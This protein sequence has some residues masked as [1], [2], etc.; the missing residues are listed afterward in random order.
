MNIKNLSVLFLSLVVL[1]ACVAGSDSSETV[2]ASNQTTTNYVPPVTQ[3]VTPPVTPPTSPPSTASWLRIPMH[4]KILLGQPQ[5]WNEQQ[6]TLALNL[7]EYAAKGSSTLKLS[8]SASLVR[9]QLLSYRGRDGQY[10]SAQI[11]SISN[12]N[13]QLSTPLQQDVFAGGNAWDFYDDGSHPTWVGSR[14]IADF[15][16]RYLGYNR[17]NQG[18]HVLLG[19]SW[20]SRQSL[21]LRL[22]ERLPAANII[23]KGVG[24]HTAAD[25][26]ARFNADVTWQNPN[27]VWIMTGTNDYWK[28]VS[29]AT[30][31]SNMRALINRVRAIGA[32]PIVFDSSVG[33]L[34]F[35]SDAKTRL[36]R[37]YVS[38]IE[39]L[40]SEN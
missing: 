12:N 3:S 30:Y 39:Q 32:V 18:K 17:L 2:S 31:K 28:N 37:S 6:G 19:D 7:R 22:R 8:S 40:A 14:V 34:N 38:S 15:S 25:L 4:Y 23:N 10:Y 24:G 33:P 1:T 16:I 29:A 21:F 35:G 36:S 27:Y 9:Q 26:L 5:V 20:F 11:Q 13:V